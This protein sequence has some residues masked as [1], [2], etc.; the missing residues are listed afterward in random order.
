MVE[1]LKGG[2]KHGRGHIVCLDEIGIERV[3]P[4]HTA[5][6]N[7][8]VG[9]LETGVG[10]ELLAHQSVKLVEQLKRPSR[11]V[12]DNAVG[13]G[14]PQRA[15]VFDDAVDFA[16]LRIKGYPAEGVGSGIVEAKPLHR[17]CPKTAVHI[18]MHTVHLVGR[19]RVA[20]LRR[21]V[22]P[23]PS[24]GRVIAVESCPLRGKPQIAPAVFINVD[25]QCPR[26]MH[27][28]KAVGGR[29]VETDALHGGRPEPAAAVAMEG[30]AA[31]HVESVGSGV[32]PEGTRPSVQ[33]QHTVGISTHPEVIAVGAK[34]MYV[35]T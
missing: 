18:D 30:I 23:P 26:A 22:L 4:L 13:S 11:R 3:E 10:Q 5:K 16:H 34:S 29:P 1:N 12:F 6:E 21:A 19:Q 35:V 2:D 17:A 20:V 15:L 28:H 9:S 14:Q 7:A 27:R 25:D 32:S 33:A 24:G 31:T 8:P